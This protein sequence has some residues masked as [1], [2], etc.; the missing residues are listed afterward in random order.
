VTLPQRYRGYEEKKMTTYELTA[1]SGDTIQL[2]S[3]DTLTLAIGDPE[4]ESEET[5][6]ALLADCF[7]RA[8]LM[9]LAEIAPSEAYEEGKL[10][11][12]IKLA[13]D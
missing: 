13:C 9:R 2:Y 6:P 3:D 12:A 1:K 4:T 5:T 10:A 11:A 7:S 8:E